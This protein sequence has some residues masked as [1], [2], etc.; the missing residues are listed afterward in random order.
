MG[1]TASSLTFTTTMALVPFFTVALA[2]FTAFPMFS[3]LQSV[4]QRWLVD[5]LVPP[6]IA[7]QVLGY[8]TQ[9]A[10]KAS[11]LGVAGLAVLL[12]T[13]LALILTMDRTLNAIWRVHRPRPLGQRVLIYWAG[14]TLGPLLLAASLAITSYVVTASRGLVG[15]MPGG[16][17]LLLNALEFGL[18]G[19]A[20]AALYRYVPNTQ[21]R[22]GHALTGGFFAAI[23]FELTKKLLTLYLGMVPT[24][25]AVYGAFA[26][27][28]ILLVWIYLAWVIVLLGAV[29]AAYMP[30]LLAGVQRRGGTPGWEF[31]LAVETLQELRASRIAGG[32]GLSAE[33]IAERL[34]VNPVQ[35]ESVLQILRM[36]DWVGTLE[37]E[38]AR[39]VLLA[40]PATT[41][42]K[43]LCDA[44]LLQPGA[45]TRFWSEKAYSP[46]WNLDSLL[47]KA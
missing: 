13:A 39:Y 37:E 27:V 46:A 42:I 38:G 23:S 32:K 29:V 7:N 19:T 44:L 30:S 40:E 21:V 9:F 26:T 28:P 6:S 5:S 11:R 22:W 33:A 34:R 20:M 14:L 45:S 31:T 25:A 15:G 36:L 35:L 24:Y 1:L 18:L 43:P 47:S 8:L 17:R 12:V 2:V 10:S 4:L 16:L 41:P 3:T